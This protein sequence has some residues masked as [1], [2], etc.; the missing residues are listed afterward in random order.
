MYVTQLIGGF[1]GCSNIYPI[2][3][4]LRI[5]IINEYI[6]PIN[7]RHIV[8]SLAMTEIDTRKRNIE[9]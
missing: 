2:H 8:L 7:S 5:F 1:S 9:R 6:Q 3:D 4:N